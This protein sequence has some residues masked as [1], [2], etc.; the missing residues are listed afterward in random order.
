MQLTFNNKQE[1][2]AFFGYTLN[3]HNRIA[4]LFKERRPTHLAVMCAFIRCG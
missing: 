1:I 3:C 4:G 2:Y